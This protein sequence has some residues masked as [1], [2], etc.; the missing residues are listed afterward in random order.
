MAVWTSS[1]DGPSNLTGGFGD[2]ATALAELASLDPEG[3][4]GASPLADSLCEA[5]DALVDAFPNSSHGDRILAVSSAG[6]ENNSQGECSG[7]DSISSV[8]PFDPGSWQRNVLDKLI[9]QGVVQVRLWNALSRAR[10]TLL[11]GQ[12]KAPAPDTGLLEALA[13]SSGG[14]LSQVE[15]ADTTPPAPFFDVGAGSRC[16]P[17]TTSLCL[18]G[19]RFRVE[20][21]WVLTS[22]K[23][24]SG[25]ARPLTEDTGLFWFFNKE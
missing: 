11:A 5:S 19:G 18:N 17:T 20:V 22:G 2:Q 25:I 13:F 14:S 3:C 9:D 1:G 10:S 4:G 24:G 7:P 15:D 12:R 8:P 23:S 16:T 21:D 6:I